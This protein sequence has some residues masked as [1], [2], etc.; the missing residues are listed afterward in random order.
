MKKIKVFCKNNLLSLDEAE[1]ITGIKKST[2]YARFKKYKT[3][4][5]KDTRKN[6]KLINLK[7]FVFSENRKKDIE[8]LRKL[9][10][11]FQQIGEVF[12]I[13]RQVVHQIFKK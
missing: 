8:S 4:N 13:S 11:T 1:K 3:I 10:C 9:G 7:Y 12:N 2:L 5:I 6:K